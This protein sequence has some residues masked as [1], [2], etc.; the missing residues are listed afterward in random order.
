VIEE[1]WQVRQVP[2]W[3]RTVLQ[4]GLLAIGAPLTLLSG[5]RAA[6]LAVAAAV[7]AYAA[8]QLPRLRRWRP[9]WTPRSM[10]LATVGVT[11]LSVGLLVVVPRLTAITSVLYRGVLWRDT[12]AAWSSSPLFGIG[13]GTMQFARQAAAD[14]LTFPER[15]PHSHNIA[16]GVLGDAGVLGLAA[17]I[18]LLAAFA[19]FAGPWRSRSVTGRA[20]SAVLIGFVVAGMF[21]DLTFEPAFSVLVLLLAAVALADAGAVRW[22]PLRHLGPLGAACAAAFVAIV[23]ALGFLGDAAAI[24]YRNGTDAASAADWQRA[25]ADLER[26]V[27]LDPWH[28]AG[29]KSLTVAADATAD[30]DAARLAAEH[31]VRL[32]AGDGAAWANLALLH[33]AYGDDE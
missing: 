16:L 21:E 22:G 28:P 25:H 7:V 11:A 15:Q 14:D 3:L 9:R 12:L 13:P 27:Q 17:A 31:A 6:W 2:R 10:G 5:S 30:R 33:L 20:A 1:L 24:M 23:A 18:V 26:A 29:P 8:P 19:W 32:N 4:I